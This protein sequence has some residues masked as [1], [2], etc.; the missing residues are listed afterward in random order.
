MAISLP[1][2]PAQESIPIGWIACGNWGTGIS[3]IDLG[4]IGNAAM[5]TASREVQRV[6]YLALYGIHLGPLRYLNSS[7]IL[8]PYPQVGGGAFVVS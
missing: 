5:G 4:N 1:A 6:C 8:G 3:A 7:T 2:E